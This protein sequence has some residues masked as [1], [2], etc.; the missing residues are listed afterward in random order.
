MT[1]QIA[2]LFS[3]KAIFKY[4]LLFVISIIFFGV[5]HSSWSQVEKTF[6]PFSTASVEWNEVLGAIEL[7][8]RTE[9]ELRESLK[10]DLD[11]V[12]LEASAVR[13]D[14][15]EKLN[16]WNSLL[17]ALG[18]LAEGETEPEAIAVERQRLTAERDDYFTRVKI[19]DLVIARVNLILTKQAKK[20]QKAEVHDYFDHGAIPLLPK[21][22]SAI[23]SDVNR[24]VQ[25]SEVSGKTVSHSGRYQDVFSL[26]SLETRSLVVTMQLGFFLTLLAFIFR[27]FYKSSRR[28]ARLYLHPNIIIKVVFRFAI[29]LISVGIAFLLLFVILLLSAFIV[30]YSVGSVANITVDQLTPLQLLSATNASV[31]NR[32]IVNAIEMVLIYI[33]LNAFLSPRLPRFALAKLPVPKLTNITYHIPLL[34]FYATLCEEFYLTLKASEAHS[35]TI[36]LLMFASLTIFAMYVNTLRKHYLSLIPTKSNDAEQIGEEHEDKSNAVEIERAESAEWSK[37]VTNKAVYIVLCFIILVSAFGYTYMATQIAVAIS[38]VVVSYVVLKGLRTVLYELVAYLATIIRREVN[39]TKY[40]EIN[41][42]K[43]GVQLKPEKPPLLLIVWGII[44]NVIAIIAFLSITMLILGFPLE[45]IIGYI[46][47]LSNGISIGEETISPRNI[48]DGLFV[49][50]VGIVLAKF[51]NR[52]IIKSKALSMAAS[53]GVRYSIGTI[54]QYVVMILSFLL[55]ISVMGLD[56]SSLSLFAGALGVGI[57][58]GLQKVVMNFISGLILLIQRPLQIG[59]WVEIGPNS[60]IVKRVNLMNTELETWQ[61]ANVIFPNADVMTAT[62]V[63]RTRGSKQGRIEVKIGVAYGSD[64]DK[65]KQVLID[66]A[67]SHPMV[68]KYQPISVIFLDFADSSLNFE[69]RCFTHDVFSV[70]GISSDLRFAINEA[71]EKENIEI[72][73]PQRILHHI[74]NAQKNTV[75]SELEASKPSARNKLIKTENAAGPDIDVGSDADAGGDD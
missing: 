32:I 75:E 44:L 56:L 15:V 35:A 74:D 36:T 27:A 47:S 8:Q 26:L 68:M 13:A 48:V 5:Q 52:T 61:R 29:A 45:S 24:F 25:W 57:G 66:C 31:A 1:H 39:A 50:I 33:V 40:P 10:V 34:Y 23:V 42:A 67:I 63:N 22:W 64:L 19:S 70:L 28:L 71:F 20:L 2:S 73:F 3:S 7:S 60:G 16:Y 58:F 4:I 65:V 72:P 17:G 9:G 12:S 43:H 59:D 21:N 49:L 30:K 69:L 37:R 51:L 38:L 53:E 11:E 6:R 55:A 54:T 14:A 18:E 62:F 41:L 46:K